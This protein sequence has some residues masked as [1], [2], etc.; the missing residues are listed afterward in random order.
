MGEGSYDDSDRLKRRQ[1]RAAVLRTAMAMAYSGKNLPFL[2]RG[3]ETGAAVLS[4]R[5]LLPQRRYGRRPC[6]FTPIGSPC[7]NRGGYQSTD[8][9]G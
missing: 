6:T 3:A 9:H 4:T 1:P 5:D 7:D 8:R 2:E